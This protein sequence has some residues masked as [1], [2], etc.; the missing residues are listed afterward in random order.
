MTDSNNFEQNLITHEM[1]PEE[2]NITSKS[3]MVFQTSFTGIMEMYSDEE[4]VSEYLND[5]QGWFIRCAE[6]MTAT[7]FG[8]N[9]YTLTIGNYGA[10]GYHLEP[11]MSVILEPPESKRYSMYSVPNPQF[12]SSYEVNYRSN[13]QIES[14]PVSQAAKGIKKVY[15]KQ[16]KANLPEQ[17]TK[18][19]WTLNLL[20]KIEFPNFISQLPMSV[21]KSTG[22]RLLAQIVKQISPRLS[23]KVQRD[24]HTRFDL[25]IPP[26]DSR[27]CQPLN[28]KLG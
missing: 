14:I 20:V 4:T 26:A 9:G 12:T 15:R 16:G 3:V 19:D 1:L 11:Q 28:A 21:I 8:N 25:P 24:F 13:L 17:I 6:P 5:H 18:I 27:T 23:Y 10:F 2:S 22:N 7:P